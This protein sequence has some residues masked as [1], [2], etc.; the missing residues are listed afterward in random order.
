M[1]LSLLGVVRIVVHWVTFDCGHNWSVRA[2]AQSSGERFGSDDPEQKRA[3]GD[4]TASVQA[5]QERALH[6]ADGL[7]CERRCSVAVDCVSGC[8]TWCGQGGMR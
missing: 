3:V 6:V 1:L 5:G 4:V 7:V 8:D 2:S